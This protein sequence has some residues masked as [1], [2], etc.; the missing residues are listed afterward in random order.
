MHYAPPLFGIRIKLRILVW[1]WVASAK[2]AGNKKTA[3]QFG[4]QRT[5]SKSDAIQADK[6]VSF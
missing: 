4:H 1:F 2:D 3:T 6:A 5:R